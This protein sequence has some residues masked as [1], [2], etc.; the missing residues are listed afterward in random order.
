MIN[1]FIGEYRN[2]V[3]DKNS[4]E[5]ISNLIRFSDNKIIIGKTVVAELKGFNF[6]IKYSF[7]KKKNFNSKILN[8][9]LLFFAQ[10]KITK[11]KN[12]NFKDL[13]FNIDGQIFWE[14]NLIAHL[15]KGQKL[16]NPRIKI[17]TDSYFKKYE[18]KINV[19][20]ENFFSHHLKKNLTFLDLIS[21]T[22]TSSVSQRAIFFALEE[23][24]GH[25]F[26]DEIYNFY[27]NLK[28][29]VQKI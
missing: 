22:E 29:K 3:I 12:C 10:Q 5:N 1:Q 8:K 6:L 24:L 18:K 2:V 9:N 23:G 27:Y 28:K 7:K 19:K 25:C 16:L 4:N 26:K 17:Y 15:L 21:G 13:S 14:K 11:F 20:I